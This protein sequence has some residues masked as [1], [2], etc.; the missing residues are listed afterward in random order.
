[1]Y[2]PREEESLPY[3][4]GDNTEIAGGSTVSPAQRVGMGPEPG[5]P[6]GQDSALDCGRRSFIFFLVHPKVL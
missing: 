4:A 6:Q 3:L 2:P 5:F 1:M